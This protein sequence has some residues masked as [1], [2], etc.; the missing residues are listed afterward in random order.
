[1]GMLLWCSSC[2]TM[3]RISSR[4][5]LLPK[6]LVQNAVFGA[7]REVINTRI[8]EKNTNL[9]ALQWQTGPAR[10][11]VVV[12]Q[13]P[14]RDMNEHV[15]FSSSVNHGRHHFWLVRWLQLTEKL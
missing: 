4:R 15:L 1:M 8:L 12:D 5:G 11:E 7:M 2:W 14:N 6:A 3:G 10:F 9:R 13:N